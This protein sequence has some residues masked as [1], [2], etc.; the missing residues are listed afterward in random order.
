[1]D[2]THPRASILVAWLFLRLVPA[3]AI[4][5]IYQALYVLGRPLAGKRRQ[6][7]TAYE[8]TDR[9]IHQIEETR[10]RSR[11]AKLFSNS[12]NDIELLTNIYYASLFSQHQ[13]EKADVIRA[14][15][16]WKRLRIR[17]L[18][19][20]MSVFLVRIILST[21]KNFRPQHRDPEISLGSPSHRPDSSPG[22]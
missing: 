1:M 11:L 20:R 3:A 14:L 10:K 22:D 2:I 15:K 9:L 6:A 19:A 13:T 21:S 7:E 16:T 4:E 18:I 12:E 5:R 17:I 8:F